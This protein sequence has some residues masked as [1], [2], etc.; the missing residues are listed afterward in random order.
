MQ[1]NADFYVLR[2]IDPCSQISGLGTIGKVPA[3]KR[4]RQKNFRALLITG[5]SLGQK[6]GDAWPLAPTGFVRA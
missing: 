2:V 4:N 1:T 5:L 6:L 3:E